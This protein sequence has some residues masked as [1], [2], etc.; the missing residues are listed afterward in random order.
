MRHYRVEARERHEKWPVVAHRPRFGIHRSMTRNEP[1]V[2]KCIVDELTFD[3][4]TS[5]RVTW[6][7]WEFTV[8]GPYQVEVTNAS[9]G[10]EK[11]DHR[12]VVGVAERDGVVVPAECGCK[13]DRF[14]TQDCKH[15]LAVATVGGPVVLEAATAFETSTPNTDPTSVTT[16]ADQL[17]ADG[18]VVVEQDPESA[19]AHSDDDTG[20]CGCEEL[21]GEFPCADCYINGEKDFPE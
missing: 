13:A 19:T 20:D 3:V 21:P 18:G 2:E 14:H 1:A 6:E 8:V 16:V 4:K 5:K 7:A 17:R 15:K 10:V 9:W 11:A 12:Y